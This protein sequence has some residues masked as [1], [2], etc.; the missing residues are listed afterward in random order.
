MPF[1][2]IHG[3]DD[4]IALPKSTDYVC[5]H[6]G[7]P[8]A[9]QQKH[10]IAN[11]KHEPFHEIESIRTAAFALVVQYFETQY[12]NKDLVVEDSSVVITDTVASTVG[13][14]V[15]AT[16]AAAGGES[17]STAEDVLDAAD[18]NIGVELTSK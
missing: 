8:A 2:C 13:A 14:T 11:A 17:T 16:A 9:L 5:E 6:I 18:I 15:E 7:T 3:A 1:L 12:L 10:I 4:L